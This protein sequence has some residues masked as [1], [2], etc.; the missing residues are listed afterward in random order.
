MQIPVAGRLLKVQ[1]FRCLLH[2]F[3]Q[4]P[5][6]LIIV[7]V[8]KLHGPGQLLP[9]L[10]PADVALAGGHTLLDM[11]IQTGT[12]AAD[13]PGQTAVAGAQAEQLIQQFNGILHCRRAGIR[14]IIAGFVFLHLP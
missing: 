1:A 2:L 12:V 11:I 6:N 4:L 8:Q 13:V 7:A 9:V 3:F 10:F 5:E 14:T